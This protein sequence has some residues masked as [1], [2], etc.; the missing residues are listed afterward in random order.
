MGEEVAEGAEN[1]WRTFP[2]AGVLLSLQ[3][4][5]LTE[6]FQDCDE[7]L[8]EAALENGLLRRQGS[9]PKKK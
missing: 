7:K 9:E 6:L 1:G 3:G 2:R 5:P 8:S 4:S